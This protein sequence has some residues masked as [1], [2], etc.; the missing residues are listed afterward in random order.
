VFYFIVPNVYRNIADFVVADHVNHF[1]EASAR[2]LLERNGFADVQ[3]D[4]EAHDAAFVVT[5]RNTVRQSAHAALPSADEVAN[6]HSQALGMSEFWKGI[7][8]KIRAFEGGLPSRAV[9][10]IYGA[11]FYANFIALSLKHPERI[12]AF[13]DQNPHLQG[14]TL[15]DRPVIAP[16]ALPP[17]VTHVL[18]GL[19]PRIAR[20]SIQS[21]AA[22]SGRP[23]E[24]LYL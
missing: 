7:V 21:I 13:V 10:E 22:W 1:S 19:N 9:P 5:A 3:V 20:A 2:V 12:C 6:L 4:G 23:L 24:F 17:D 14:T 15:R 18:V 8:G 11:G 16:D